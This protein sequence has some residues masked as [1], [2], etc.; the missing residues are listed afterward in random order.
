[1]STDELP[2]TLMP[3]MENPLL[4]HLGIRLTAWEPGHATF[5]LEIEPRHLNLQRSLQGGVI[6][7]MLDVA[8]GYAGLR[9]RPG[10][11]PVNAATVMLN[12][13]YSA[14][15]K[16]GTVVAQGRVTGGGRRIYLA[17]AELLAKDGTLIATAQG[18]FRRSTP[19]G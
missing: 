18:A 1:M 2:G 9:M 12:I 19:Q 5:S 16:E 11:P 6:A 7:T 3:K 4:D 8:C 15:V 14:G 13:G 10:Q 17:S